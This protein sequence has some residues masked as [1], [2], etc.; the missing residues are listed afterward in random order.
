MKYT[1]D[2][3]ERSVGRVASEAATL[4]MGKSLKD[5]KRNT[6]PEVKVEIKNGA[7]V[8]IT[9]TKLTQS[10]HKK[11][12]GYPGGLKIMPIKDVIKKNG[13]KDVIKHAVSGMLPK[14]KLRAKMIK[15]LI[16]TD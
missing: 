4:L 1:I 9:G 13:Y 3:E 14:N 10:T 8:K 12:S 5:F 11:Y 2:A 6:T 15:N 7:K 16:I